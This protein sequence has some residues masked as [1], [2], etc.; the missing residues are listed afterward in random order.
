MGRWGWHREQDGGGG[1]A[2]VRRPR[3]FELQRSRGDTSNG[4]QL[5]QA[6]PRLFCLGGSCHAWWHVPKQMCSGP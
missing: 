1:D 3:T 6:V 4:T 5:T 2:E